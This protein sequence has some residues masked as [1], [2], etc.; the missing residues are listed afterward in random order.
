MHEGY[1]LKNKQARFTHHLPQLKT[2]KVKSHIPT[3][4][5]ALNPIDEKTLISEIRDIDTSLN[6]Q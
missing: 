1:L 6:S 2:K 3:S 4:L 5:Q